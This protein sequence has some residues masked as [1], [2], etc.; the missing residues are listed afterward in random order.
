MYSDVLKELED[1]KEI[2]VEN[3]NLPCS[4]CDGDCCGPDVQF[5]TEELKLIE[6]KVSIKK[7]KKEAVLDGNSYMLSTKGVKNKKCVFLKNNK[8][9]IYNARPKICKDY[10]EKIYIQCPYNGLKEIP[11]SLEERTKLTI[12]VQDV[13][14][15]KVSEILGVRL[16]LTPHT[17]KNALAKYKE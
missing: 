14:Y 16:N 1:F 15:N 7:F 3:I 4:K 6:S 11:D 12:K 5:S 9:S 8:C 17:A 2:D 13:F 10:G